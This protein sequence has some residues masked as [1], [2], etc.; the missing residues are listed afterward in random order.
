MSSFGWAFFGFSGG[1][2]AGL[3]GGGFGGCGLGGGVSSTC[4]IRSAMAVESGGG[5]SAL[6]FSF[7]GSGLASGGGGGSGLAS[8]AAVTSL[9]A[10]FSVGSAFFCSCAFL[11]AGFSTFAGA[12]G[13]IVHSAGV[14]VTHALRRYLS[15][16]ALLDGSQTLYQGVPITEDRLTAGLRLDWKLNRSVVVR[17]S[18]THEQLDS[19]I[20]GAD[21]TANVY[22]VGLRL[23]R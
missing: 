13:A 9:S 8:L 23:Q 7:G 12:S 2:F 5:G 6:G 3:G 15:L 11:G 1:F 21:Y 18:V 22:L 17:A 14:E 4:F 16:S 10:T 20:P 19:S